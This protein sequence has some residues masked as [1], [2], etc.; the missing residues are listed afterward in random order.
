MIFPKVR[1]IQHNARKESFITE[2]TQESKDILK[3]WLWADY[4]LYDYFKERHRVFSKDFG[5]ERLAT[6]VQYLQ[7]QNAEVK[8][9]CVSSSSLGSRRGDKIFSPW[10]KKVE[11]VVPNRLKRWCFPFFKTEIA[12]TRSIRIMNRVNVRKNFRLKVRN[13]KELIKRKKSKTSKP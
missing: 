2:M 4:L 10:S 11:A 13:R 3:D 9:Q 7:K 5:E 8:T 1:Y 12:Y 6:A